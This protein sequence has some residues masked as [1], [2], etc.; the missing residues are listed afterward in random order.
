MSLPCVHELALTV[1]QLNETVTALQQQQTPVRR[2]WYQRLTVETWG[3]DN[4]A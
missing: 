1:H 4:R 2:R 3:E